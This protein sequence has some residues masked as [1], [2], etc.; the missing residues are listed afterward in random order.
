MHADG[1][2]MPA[3]LK[4]CHIL[5]QL[6]SGHGLKFVSLYRAIRLKLSCFLLLFAG[7]RQDTALTEATAA[8]FR[9]LS[10]ILFSCIPLILII[11]PTRCTNFSNLFWNEILHVS[12]SSSI[13][14]QE[15]FTVTQQ[16]YMSYSF[17][18]S[19]RAGSG[20]NWQF[21]SHP[22]SFRTG[23]GWNWQFR[24]VPARKLSANLYDIYR[25]CMYSEKLLMMGRG[26]VQNM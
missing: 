12:D 2:S 26:T 21:H 5:S 11:K 9:V 16:W 10:I 20:C 19:F 7:I 18:D 23:S 13:H 6:V 22:D 15:F 3:R 24:S 4:Q 14:H 25:C 1:D 17:E 8:F